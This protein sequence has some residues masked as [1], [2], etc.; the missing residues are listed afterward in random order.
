[1]REQPIDRPLSS[2]FAV[3]ADFGMEGSDNMRL[4]GKL[5]DLQ[6]NDEKRS[7]AP[8]DVYLDLTS[9]RDSVH[10]ALDGGDFHLNTA[11]NGSVDQMA[12]TGNKLVKTLREQIHN[13]RIDQPAIIRLLLNRLPRP[14]RKVKCPIGNK[15]MIAGW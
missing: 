7:Y 4:N 2:K 13:R 11:F 14:L 3:N 8:G 6:V 10:V 9:M 5:A 12:K 1:M 15:R